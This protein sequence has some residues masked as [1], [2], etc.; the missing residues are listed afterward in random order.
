MGI[1]ELI[2]GFLNRG[3]IVLIITANISDTLEIPDRL[4]VVEDGTCTA[5]Y[6]KH[7]FNRIVR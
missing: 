3:T 4:L 6:E 5:A 7:E 2:C 1:L